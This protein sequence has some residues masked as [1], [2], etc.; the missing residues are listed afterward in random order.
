MRTLTNLS[1]LLE[2]SIG[3]DY[4][5]DWLENATRVEPIENWPPY[6]IEKTGEESYRI[7]MA[8]AG[9]VPEDLEVIAQRNL[10]VV[11]GK[12]ATQNESSG[13]LYRGIAARSFVRRFQ[14]A[15]FVE[16]AHAELHDGLLLIDLMRDVPE[17]M[18]PKRIPVTPGAAAPKPKPQ[19]IKQ[20]QA[21]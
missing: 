2:S 11:S 20:K 6:D 5:Y 3:F 18:K 21:A 8:V 19:Q 10:L 17:A 13:V 14:L 16:V 4:L 12:K 9:F 15:D 7:T 1:P